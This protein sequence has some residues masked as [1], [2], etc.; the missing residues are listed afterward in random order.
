MTLEVIS[1][2][3][4]G[5]LIA[6]AIVGGGFEIKEI[7]MPRVGP[8]ARS[9]ALVVG[10]LFILMGL[11]IWETA[12]QQ[13]IDVGSARSSLVSPHP[14]QDAPAPSRT[15]PAEQSVPAAQPVA[16]V[17][18]PPSQVQPQAQG[19]TG[20]ARLTWSIYGTP[21]E[22]VIQTFGQHGVVRVAYTGQS[23][24]VEQVD[25]DLVLEQGVNLL[26]YRGANPRYAGTSTPH[27]TYSP[28]AFRLVEM[29]SGVWSITE[30]C[31]EQGVCAPVQTQPIP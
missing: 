27:P 13:G 12:R 4:G 5:L 19:I 24:T 18:Q 8:G 26:F 6:T 7:K 1:F 28:D 16:T 22:A 31:D 23:G 9:G 30:V 10:T 17:E 14:A 21:Y 25:Q 2:A 29:Q 11:G 15:A 3:I 20:Q